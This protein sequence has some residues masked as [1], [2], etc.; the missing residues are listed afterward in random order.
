MNT[1]TSKAVGQ[2]YDAPSRRVHVGGCPVDPM[3]TDEVINQILES[4]RTKKRQQV[5]GINAASTVAAADS[6][7]YRHLL[8]GMTMLPVDGFWVAMAARVLGVTGTPHVGIER[9]VYALLPKIASGNGSV[10]LL[11]AAPDVVD[12]AARA[13]E[14][15]YPGLR[16]VGSHHGYFSKTDEPAILRS[17]SDVE[18]DLILVGMSSPR[19]EQWAH[20]NKDALVPCTIIGVGGLFDVLAGRIAPAPDFLKNIG[21]E[22]AFRFAH[23]PRRLWQRYTIGNL[24]FL[25]MIASARFRRAI[26]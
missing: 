26:S 19:K 13:V 4:I 14:K 16:V 15:T 6:P 20:D 10:Y 21:L 3:S 1:E 7:D 18:P 23:D 5:Y 9:L 8:D 11:G 17:I 22:W 24:R 12:D 25:S 2:T